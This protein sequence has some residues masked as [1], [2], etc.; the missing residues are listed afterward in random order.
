MKGVSIIIKYILIILVDKGEFT[1]EKNTRWLY[2]YFANLSHN[3]YYKF[4]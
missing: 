2:F 1:I 4:Y 3:N